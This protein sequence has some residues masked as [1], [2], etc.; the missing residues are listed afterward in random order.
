MQA[1]RRTR[2]SGFTLVEI[3]IVVIILG[4][5]AAIVIPQFTNA[6][7]DARRSSLASTVQTLRS[8]I[9]LY[10]LQH[11]DTAPAQATF[12]DQ[13]TLYSDDAGNTQATKDATYKFGPYVQTIPVNSMVSDANKD[14]VTAVTATP[15][16]PGATEAATGYWYEVSSGKVWAQGKD[17]DGNFTVIGD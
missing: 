11:H 3:L 5:L 14:V 10:K 2:K 9:S 15:T 8:Q 16:A 1:I 6:S 13:L 12:W 4:I 17:D 7:Q